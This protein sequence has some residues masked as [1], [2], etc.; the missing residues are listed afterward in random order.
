MLEHVQRAIKLVQSSKDKPCVEWMRE[1][2]LFSPQKMKLRETSS[3][4]TARSLE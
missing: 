1:L 3:P 2:G 4:S